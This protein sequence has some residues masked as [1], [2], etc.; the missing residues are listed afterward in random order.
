MA[1]HAHFVIPPLILIVASCR[2]ARNLLL[3]RALIYDCC[4][5]PSPSLWWVPGPRQVEI[6]SRGGRVPSNPLLGRILYKGKRVSALPHNLV[7]CSRSRSCVMRAGCASDAR[8]MRQHSK[9]N[10]IQSDFWATLG[11]LSSYLL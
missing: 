5:W 7:I 9:N 6:V 2:A 3:C 4:I 1:V 8:W 10:L 11:A